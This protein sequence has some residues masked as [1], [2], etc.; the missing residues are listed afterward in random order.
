MQLALPAWLAMQHRASAPANFLTKYA[1]IDWWIKKLQEL[2]KREVHVSC[3]SWVQLE[4]KQSSLGNSTN[5]WSGR[6]QPPKQA[7]AMAWL[8][9]ALSPLVAGCIRR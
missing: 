1:L 5:V 7:P 4:H 2:W 3:Y 9:Q 8:H 6:N